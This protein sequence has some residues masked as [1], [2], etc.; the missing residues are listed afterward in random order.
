MMRDPHGAARTPSRD[1]WF[2]AVVQQVFMA[3]FFAMFSK[4]VL[5]PRR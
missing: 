3:I 5:P 4:S 1:E 2:R